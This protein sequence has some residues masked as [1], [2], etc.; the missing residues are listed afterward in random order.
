MRGL[1]VGGGALGVPAH[2]LDPQRHVADQRVGVHRR[3]FA[4]QALGIFAKAVEREPAFV[5]QQIQRRYRPRRH[6]H[7]RQRNPAIADNDRRDPLRHLAQHTGRP[8]QHRSVVMRVRVDKAGC[9]RQ[10]IGIDIAVCLVN[11]QV[12]DREDP[13]ASDRHVGFKS[14]RSQAIEHN[15]IPDNQIAAQRHELVPFISFVGDREVNRNVAS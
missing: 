6:P 5:A 2:C 8:A 9:Q 7:R 4:R 1:P 13:V 12:A 11:A 15:G 14:R 10:S 3:R